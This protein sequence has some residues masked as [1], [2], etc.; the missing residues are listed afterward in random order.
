MAGSAFFSILTASLNNG[1]TI[2]N[3]LESLKNQTCQDLEHIVID[4]GS[5]DDSLRIMKNYEDAYNLWW[6][7]ESDRGI[8]DALNKGLAKSRGTYVVVIQSDDRFLHQ[9]VLKKVF[10]LLRDEVYDIYSFP[11]IMR[12]PIYGDIT[13]KPVRMLWWNRFKLIFPHQGTFVHRRVYERIGGYREDFSI[14]MDYDFFYRAILACRTV[15][16]HR[17]PAV[18]LMGGSG[19][20]T[21]LDFVHRRLK[22]EFLVQKM[23]ERNPLW[24]MGQ[25]LFKS[26]YRPYKIRLLPRLKAAGKGRGTVPSAPHPPEHRLL[27]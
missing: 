19:I 21:R 7:S 9:E 3:T 18:A 4:G 26:L 16:F 24:R 25:I 12:H 23:N 22:E 15:K 8:A 27:E 13:R 10:P 2:R 1:A 6:I 17:Q 5:T 11:V 20:G 14:A